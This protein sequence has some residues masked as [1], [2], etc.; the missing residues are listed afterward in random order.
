[1]MKDAETNLLSPVEVAACTC[2]NL[3]KTTRMVTQAYD[4][5]LQPV[6][7]KGTQFTLLA[8]LAKLG[9]VPLSRLAKGLVLDR[10]TLTR[11]LKPLVARGLIAIGHEQDQR[12]RTISITDDGRRLLEEA[13]PNWQRAQSRMV[14]GLGHQRWSVLLD[15]LAATLAVVHN[16]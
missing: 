3:R 12:V 1:M 9:D 8:R 4:A 16:G 14:E 2:A 5:A 15:D 10:T 6:G 11:N 13:I 7:L